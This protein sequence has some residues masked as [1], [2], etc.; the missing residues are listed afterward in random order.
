[1]N[2]KPFPN[3]EI[4]KNIS[5]ISQDDFTS[6]DTVINNI[7]LGL[8]M[9][10]EDVDVYEKEMV[11][12]RVRLVAKKFNIDDTFMNLKNGYFTK[13]GSRGSNLSSGERQKIAILRAYLKNARYLFL[14]KQQVF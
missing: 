14:M 2:I 1:M 10:M 8:N 5:Y 12:K 4:I 11:L 6:D 9:R 13:V 3:K 7:L